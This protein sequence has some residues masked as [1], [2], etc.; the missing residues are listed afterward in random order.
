MSIPF[1]QR[2]VGLFI[3]MLPWSDAIPF[4]RNLFQQFPFL[5]WLAIPALPLMILQQAIPFG[6]LILFLILFLAVIRNPKVPYFLRFNTLQG[7]LIDIAVVL[8][9]YAFQILLQPIGGGLFT[10]TLSST[11]FVGILTIM[12]FA[13]SECI[14]G[15]EPDL[16]GISEAVR[17]QL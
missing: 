14:Q 10:R 7:L 15:K 17:I 12:I 2:I 1:W 8:I 4:G 9:S 6:S 13:I 11:A 5:Q 3:Y 16:P